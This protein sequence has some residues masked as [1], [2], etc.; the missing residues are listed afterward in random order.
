[1]ENELPQELELQ[2]ARWLKDER[3]QERLQAIL[4]INPA[5]YYR[6]GS[7]NIVNG[8]KIHSDGAINA[9]LS[10]MEDIIRELNPE[11]WDDNEVLLARVAKAELLKLSSGTT[12]SAN[13]NNN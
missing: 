6:C 7:I 4:E 11:F 2:V 3:N 5:Q 8:I 10:E 13:N 1:M 9:R 12:K